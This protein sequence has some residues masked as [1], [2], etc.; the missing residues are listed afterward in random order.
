MRLFRVLCLALIFIST[1]VVA[2]VDY[3]QQ[4]ATA[5]AFYREGQYNLAMEAFKPVI[6]YDKSNPFPEYASFYY[7]LSAYK[8][9][10]RSVAKDMFT[11]IKSLYPTWEQLDEVNVWLAKIHVDNRD[12][13]QAL[14]TLQSVKNNKL[15][16][17]VAQVKEAIAATVSDLETLRMM[18][19]EYS[20]DVVIATRLARILAVKSA[21]EEDRNQLESLI[22]KF[23]LKRTEFVPEA[24][25]TI[26]KDRY[27]VSV[28][29][30]FVVNTLDPTPTRKRNQF[31]LD[32][33]EGMELAVDTLAKLGIQIDLRAYDTERSP[34]K[35]NSLLALEEIRN[36]DLI[37]GPLFPEE[38][39]VVQE[40]SKTFKINSFNPVTNNFDLVREN[41]FGFLF[42]PSNETI[43]EKAAEFLAAD[44]AN[45]NCMVF[46]GESKRD[47]ALA[48]GFLNKALQA[49]MRL[50]NIER[51][52]KD[53]YKRIL[54]ILQTP[55]EFDEFKYPKQFTLPKDSVD[56]IFVGSDDPLIYAKVISAAETRGDSIQIVGSEN[57]LDQTS[58]NY[59]KY[60]SLGVVFAAPNFS[61]QNDVWYQAFQQ[62][63]IATH[64]RSS[65]GTQAYTNYAKLGYEF[66]LFVG[67][68]L[69]N[70][71]VYFQDGLSENPMTGFL[72][73]GFSY[74]GGA[75]SN[76]RVPFIQFKKGELVVI[77]NR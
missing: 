68:A 2:Q 5:K 54:D 9:G 75:R 8:Q 53:S 60:Q 24:P 18:H 49:N 77:D 26:Y 36:T 42:Q 69:K 76:Q 41:P 45:K 21:T 61:S 71:G 29:F 35:I 67:H 19:E 59:D 6:A 31:V 58:I 14:R 63:F 72:T 46:F 23:K 30:P 66:M 44:S 51:I 28:L 65:S 25:K 27:A 16:K 38:N 55:T 39:N 11:Q 57:W 48:V 64:G 20:D 4:Y 62:K 10:Y 33:F 34:Q 70:H 32:L 37:I 56:C 50:I 22:T 15:Q 13:F 12:Y 7:A 52:T 1:T 73:E 47:S 3:K 74:E 17:T 43:G 40:F